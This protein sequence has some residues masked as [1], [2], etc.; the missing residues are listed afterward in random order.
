MPMES[1][2]QLFETP[3]RDRP[4]KGNRDRL[5]GLLDRFEEEIPSDLQR[6]LAIALWFQVEFLGFLSRLNKPE[7]VR[8]LKKC[9]EVLNH[10]DG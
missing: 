9:I 10:A 8:L 4:Q 1:Q 2:L 5:S 3:E 7:R 6:D